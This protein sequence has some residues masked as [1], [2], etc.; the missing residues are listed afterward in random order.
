MPRPSKRRAVAVVVLLAAVLTLSGA[1]TARAQDE[2]G[3]PAS[4]STTLDDGT[5]PHII[6]QP[7]SGRPPTE[8]GDRGGALQLG[9][10]ALIV[11]AVGTIVGLAVRESRR[12][13]GRSS[14]RTG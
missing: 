8:A 13:R 11:V 1:S 5:L 9:L 7:N 6:P 3:D 4:T 10:L 14:S 2:P 12:A